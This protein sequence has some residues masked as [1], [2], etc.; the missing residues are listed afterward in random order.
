[1]LDQSKSEASRNIRALCG[2][3]CNCWRALTDPISLERGIGPECLKH[4]V[5]AIRTLAA[6]GRQLEIIMVLTGMPADFVTAVL[7]EV[8]AS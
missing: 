3:C 5:D 8:T 2:H 1:M 6:E 4:K 7:N